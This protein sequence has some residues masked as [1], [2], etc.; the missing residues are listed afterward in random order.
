ML[1]KKFEFEG[2][3][4][5]AVQKYLG[6]AFYVVTFFSMLIKMLSVYGRRHVGFGVC[7]HMFNHMADSFVVAIQP[8]LEDDWNKEMEEAWRMLFRLGSKNTL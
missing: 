4:L 5:I 2:W 3:D 1:Y 6:S 7:G 8:A